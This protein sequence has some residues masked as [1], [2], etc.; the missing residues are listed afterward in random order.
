M[1]TAH[2]K[3]CR[4]RLGR[5]PGVGGG[6]DVRWKRAA[7]TQALWAVFFFFPVAMAA[8]L[9]DSLA[10][11]KAVDGSC[12]EAVGDQSEVCSG[13]GWFIY[14]IVRMGALGGVILRTLVVPE[15][16]TMYLDGSSA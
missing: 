12:P 14:F 2:H 5:Y 13:Q 4:D 1:E 10:S 3:H 16:T 11:C 15:Y 6:G 9:H 7:N 8:G